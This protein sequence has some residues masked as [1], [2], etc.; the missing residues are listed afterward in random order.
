MSKLEFLLQNA[1]RR[2]EAQSQKGVFPAIADAKAANGSSEASNFDALLQTLSNRSGSGQ[3]Q[4]QQSP[5]LIAPIGSTAKELEAEQSGEV[6]DSEPLQEDMSG[7]LESRTEIA[8]P[9]QDVSSALQAGFPSFVLPQPNSAPVQQKSSSATTPGSLLELISPKDDTDAREMMQKLAS[10]SSP[11]VSVLHQE[12]HFKPVLA[13]SIPADESPQGQANSSRLPMDTSQIR[14]AETLLAA[15]RGTVGKDDGGKAAIGAA[16]VMQSEIADP[17]TSA[18][19]LQRIASAVAAESAKTEMQSDEASRVGQAP[20]SIVL[21]PSEGVLRVL[22]IQ[23][24]PAELGVVTVKMRLSGEQLEME[25]HTSSDETADI[26]R[27]DSEKLSGLL[28]S[29]GYRADIVTIHVTA[30]DAAQQDALGGQR[31]QWGAQSQSGGFQQGQAGQEE[32]ARR[33]SDGTDG[34]GHKTQ[35][36]PDDVSAVG[37]HAGGVY[38]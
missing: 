16:P 18:M 1:T 2:T 25:L 32:Q 15:G 36:G 35:N 26:L 4:V 13:N 31:Q 12:A 37:T 34:T 6:E 17:A 28:R 19:I 5:L 9:K 30:P 10:A 14:N 21:K 22:D 8:S 23:L 38:L 29:S 7:D 27:K 11:K 33:S 3:A 20:A 24:H